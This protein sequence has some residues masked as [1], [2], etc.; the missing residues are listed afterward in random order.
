MTETVDGKMMTNEFLGSLAVVYFMT[1]MAVGSSGVTNAMAA[2]LVLA[3]MMMAL[4]GAMILPWITL[5]RV[6]KQ[7]MDWQTGVLAWLMQILGGVV[8]YSID[9]WVMK[10]QGHDAMVEAAFT[11]YLSNFSLDASVILMTFIGAFLLMMVWSRLGGGWAMGIFAWMLM[12]GGI[13]VVSAGG[14]GG[15]IVTASY[16]TD[17]IVQVLGMMILGGVGAAAKKRR[18]AAL[19]AEKEEQELSDMFDNMDL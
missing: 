18:L 11:S 4:S 1:S 5:G 9:W 6:M 7:E 15:M 12:S 3:V 13:D 2:G 10:G 8:A 14:V 16:G 19:A 17:A